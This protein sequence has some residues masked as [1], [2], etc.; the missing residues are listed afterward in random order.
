[1]ENP[2]N[3]ANK[4]LPKTRILDV[5]KL[6]RRDIYLLLLLMSGVGILNLAVPV[7]VQALINTVTMGGL[8]KPLLIISVMLFVFLFLSGTFYVLEMYVVEL[9]Q[10]R[11]FIRTALDSAQKAQ[12]VEISVH[13]Q[14]NMTELMNR[15][16][17][18]MAIQKSAGSLLTIGVASVLQGLIGSII[19][20]FYSAYFA[21]VVA[22]VILIIL[23]IV[24][25]IGSNAEPTV[26]E[27]SDAKYRLAAWLET[28]ARN[29]NTF[30]FSAGLDLAMRRADQLSH[31]YLNKRKTHFR[32]LLRQGMGGAF[33]YALAGTAMLVLGGTLVIK[34]QINLGQFVAAELIIFGVLASFLRFIEQLEYYYELL[35]G[36][37]KVG[38]ILDVPQEQHGSHTLPIDG[39]L[40]LSVYNLSYD[41]LQYTAKQSSINFELEPGKNLAILGGSGS[42]KSNLAELIAG[43]RQPS[44]G[45]IEYNKIDLRLLDL[46]QVRHHIGFVAA[47]EIIEDSI[48]ENVRIG[49]S[50]ISVET[51]AALLDQLGLL[52]SIT[53]LEQGLETELTP[54]GAPLSTTQSRLLVLARALIGRPALIVIDSLLDALSEADLDLVFEVL[55]RQKENTLLI[56]TRLPHIAE[57]CEQVIHL[58]RKY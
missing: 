2:L 57:K 24:F 9:I 44:L 8:L 20:V 1:M 26:I 4:M 23:F 34:G 48:L 37:E 36:M 52:T 32:I 10:R 43:L 6:E 55:Y 56:L 16:F 28:I 39:P 53:R 13:D 3:P 35:A 51:V 27:E 11:L 12:S 19:L 38:Y 5:I 14:L 42:G 46:R 58:Q 7:A 40:K 45:H 29:L 18:I 25:A 17:E 30:K 54:T 21:L 50:D 15:F 31:Q 22:I 49:R 33:V 41:Y 47:I